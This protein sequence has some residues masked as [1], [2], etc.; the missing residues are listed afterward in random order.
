M[1]TGIKERTKAEMQAESDAYD[2]VHCEQLKT[3]CAEIR[4]NSKRFAAAVKHIMKE[5]EE[6]Q[7]AVKKENAAR[8]RAVKQ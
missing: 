4:S 7:K 6:R 2:L 3:K 5:N 8:D 1:E